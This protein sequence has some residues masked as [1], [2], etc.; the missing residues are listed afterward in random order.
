VATAAS[1]AS[2]TL[3]TIRTGKLLLINEPMTA[4]VGFWVHATI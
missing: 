4:A 3:P 2:G 1:L